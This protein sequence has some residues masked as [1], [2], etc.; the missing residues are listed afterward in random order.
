MCFSHF[1]K[2]LRYWRTVRL[3]TWFL[4]PFAYFAI[5]G[6]LLFWVVF[7]LYAVFGN[8]VLKHSIAIKTFTFLNFLRVQNSLH[9][10]FPSENRTHNQ[11][12]LQSHACSPEPRATSHEPR[13]HNWHQTETFIFIILFSTIGKCAKVS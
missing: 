4:L 7:K 3:N 8:F 5:R 10:I 2:R 11:S 9:F 13:A 6:V 12:C 1:M